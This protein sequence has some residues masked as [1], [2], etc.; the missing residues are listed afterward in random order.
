MTDTQFAYTTYIKT[1]PQKVWDAITNP[2]FTYQY[3]VHNN[4]SDWKVGSPWYHLDKKTK[5]KRVVGEV[6]ESTPPHRLV[7]TWADPATPTDQ[8]RVTFEIEAVGELVRLNVLHDQL[9][10]SSDMAGKIAIGW[11][12]VLSSMKTFLESGRPLDI[13]AIKQCA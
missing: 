7:L 3:W 6:L 12:M 5:T 4:I 13:M 2:E 9:K 10:T 1:T 8:S 11:P